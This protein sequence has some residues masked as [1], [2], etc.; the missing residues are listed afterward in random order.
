MNVFKTRGK[1]E[2]KLE[3]EAGRRIPPFIESIVMI[4]R[5][6]FP[7]NQRKILPRMA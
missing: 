3:K 6:I 5:S 7:C 2:G 4:S 1:I